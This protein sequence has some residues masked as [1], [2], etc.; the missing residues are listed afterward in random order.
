M[1]KYISRRIFEGIIT[2]WG[3]I[4]FVFL[5]IH[6]I[7][8][9]PVETILG[10]NVT[11]EDKLAF[12]KR[13]YLDKP[14]YLQYIYFIKQLFTEEL[15]RTFQDPSVTV[16]E[17]ISTVFPY[18]LEL[19]ITASIVSW[20][21]AIPFGIALAFWREGIKEEILNFF[22]L[23]NLIIPNIVLGPLL[24]RLLCI[25][26]KVFPLPG[27]LSNRVLALI[28]PSLTLGTTLSALLA[29]LIRTSI[30]E[31][32]ESRFV[33]VAQSLGIG[34][35]KLWFNYILRN[36]L[37]PAV[38]IGGLQLGVLLTGTVVTEKIFERPG[39][40][41]LFLDAFYKRDIPLIQGIVLI[42]ATI[43]VGINLT[44][45]IINGIIDPRVR[46]SAF[47]NKE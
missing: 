10:E 33:L 37:I 6:L 15:G 23:L 11:E 26:I 36:A 39:L 16:L 28:L 20:F 34:K 18:T 40:G 29:R 17:K 14:L 30:L 31:I 13:F 8:G 45:D 27:D 12:I 43:Y 44:T 24:I 1:I 7:P 47:Q 46:R 3:V 38:T 22:V 35:V 2:I 5:F 9:E 4:T 42:I 41:S 21:L 19:A 25:D 32:K